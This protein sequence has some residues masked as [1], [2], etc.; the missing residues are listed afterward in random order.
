MGNNIHSQ[1]REL[2]EALKSD[3]IKYQN[4]IGRHITQKMTDDLTDY[5][6]SVIEDFYDQYTPKE[7]IHYKRHGYFRDVPQRYYK[8]RGDVFIGGVDLINDLPDVY[9]GSYSEPEQVFNRVIFGGLH[10][11]ASLGIPKGITTIPPEFQ[12]SP[13]DRI[14]Q[15]RDEIL[16]NYLD[17]IDEAVEKSK[18]DS[19]AIL[20]K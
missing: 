3:F 8:K 6:K 19:Y 15:R 1:I 4:N 5:A 9:F 17:Y 20:F 2:R 18:K 13:Y 16:N 7:S 12:P 14:A 10:G 11:Y